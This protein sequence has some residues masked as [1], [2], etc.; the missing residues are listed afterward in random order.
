MPEQS[1]L[2]GFDAPQRKATDRIFLAA[3]PDAGAIIKMQQLTQRIKTQH[4]LTGKPIID[5]RLHITLIDLDDQVDLPSTLLDAIARAAAGISQPAFDV[6]FDQ[7]E[8]F[9]RARACLLTESARSDGFPL[10]K[11]SLAVALKAE[12][13][14][15]KKASTP[16]VTL[17]YDTKAVSRQA[18]DSVAW[19]VNEFV[20]VHSDLDRPGL[21]YNIL[22]RWPLS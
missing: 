7:V 22:A 20:L 8:F 2:P 16:H 6:V 13:V 10:L 14:P 3:L 19:T 5:G 21:P 15:R 11:Q 4:G 17:L 12:G 18:V 9:P 1:Q